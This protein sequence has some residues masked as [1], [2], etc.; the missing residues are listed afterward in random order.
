MPRLKGLHSQAL[1]VALLVEEED[2]GTRCSLR[3]KSLVDVNAVA[4]QFGGGGHARAAGLTIP[5]GLPAA[6]AKILAALSRELE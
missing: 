3:S 6:K 4:R 5:E 2:G 1:A